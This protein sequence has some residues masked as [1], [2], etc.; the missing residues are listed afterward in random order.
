MIIQINEIEAH[1]SYF[2]MME[3][4]TYEGYFYT[5]AK[6]MHNHAPIEYAESKGQRGE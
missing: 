6:E 1:D 4:A 3:E 2:D 5:I